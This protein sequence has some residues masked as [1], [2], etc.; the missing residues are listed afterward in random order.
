MGPLL[1]ALALQLAV[2]KVIVRSA[3]D[4]PGDL[5]F[6][7]FYLDDGTIAGPSDAVFWY[8]RE[9]EKELAAIG[10]AINWGVGKSEAIPSA[11]EAST[12]D[13]ASMPC[14][15]FNYSRCFKLLGAPIGNAEYCERLTEKRRKI[16]ANFDI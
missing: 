10:L 3:S 6:M 2:E 14:L 5:D 12:I 4:A 15:H 9:I 8:C 11:G 1:F 16:A 13:R 7:V